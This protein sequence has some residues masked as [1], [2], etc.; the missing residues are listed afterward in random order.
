M[1]NAARRRIA[2]RIQATDYDAM[3]RLLPGE[4]RLPEKYEDWARRASEEVARIT[5]RGDSFLAVVVTPEDLVSHCDASGEEP[6]Y[7][8]L[9]AT[10]LK[11]ADE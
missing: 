3:R 9:E 2:I 7:A 1:K 10:A 4:E 5:R 8:L 6:S 11:K